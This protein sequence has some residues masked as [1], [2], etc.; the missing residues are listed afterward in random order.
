[1]GGGIVVSVWISGY[2]YR[3]E[4]LRGGKQQ[5]PAGAVVWG[6]LAVG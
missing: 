2:F 6:A 5:R 3:E 1:V 4:G